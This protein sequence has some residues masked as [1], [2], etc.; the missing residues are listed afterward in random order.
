MIIHI[1][2][3]QN[4]V[5]GQAYITKDNCILYF[6]VLIM[7]FINERLDEKDIKLFESLN[8]K[9]PWGRVR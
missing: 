8:L 6:G 3:D 7:A 5:F 2:D 9:N 1:R 4:L